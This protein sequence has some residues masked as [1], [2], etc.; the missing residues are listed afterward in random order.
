MI[1]VSLST[2]VVT[3]PLLDLLVSNKW[4]AGK[5]HQPGVSPVCTSVDEAPMGVSAD[6]ALAGKQPDD[7][8]FGLLELRQALAA[9]SEHP[10]PKGTLE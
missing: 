8:S 10:A 5:D 4:L 7:I 9:S 3:K 1:L 6:W 2:L